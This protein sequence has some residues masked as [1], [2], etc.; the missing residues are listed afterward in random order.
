MLSVSGGQA[1]TNEEVK[2]E[3]K[4]LEETGTPP[5]LHPSSHPFQVQMQPK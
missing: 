5:L 3:G 4:Q 1:G 2:A